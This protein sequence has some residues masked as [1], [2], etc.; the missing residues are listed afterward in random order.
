[1]SPAEKHKVHVTVTQHKRLLV[2][3][4]PLRNAHIGCQ[5]LREA[6][7]TTTISWRASRQPVAVRPQPSS[8][9]H[10]AMMLGHIFTPL[11]C[12]VEE[13]GALVG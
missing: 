2:L 10:N 5:S 4:A 8:C 1:M 6:R 13:S 7:M 11:L 12:H 3:T 9:K